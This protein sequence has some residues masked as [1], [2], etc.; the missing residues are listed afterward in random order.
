MNWGL[1]TAWLIVAPGDIKSV[2][3]YT[4][5]FGT[6]WLVPRAPSRDAR[7]DPAE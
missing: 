5:T 3:M 6:F 2:P 4:L 1:P 7:I